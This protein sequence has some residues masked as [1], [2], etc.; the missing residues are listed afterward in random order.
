[1]PTKVGGAEANVW[2]VEG[3]AAVEDEY[4]KAMD[5]NDPLTSKRAITASD[6]KVSF[7]LVERYSE[8]IMEPAHRVRKYKFMLKDASRKIVLD[9]TPYAFSIKHYIDC[10][11][12][13]K[14][15]RFR[16][17]T[18]NCCVFPFLYSFIRLARDVNRGSERSTSNLGSTPIQTSQLECS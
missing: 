9:F 8:R 4:P 5:E 14:G 1:M 17:Y 7:F 15:F 13:R 18:K 12:I 3:G 16:A 2:L 11:Y 6:A 10:R